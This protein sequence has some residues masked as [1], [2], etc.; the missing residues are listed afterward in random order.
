MS[1]AITIEGT[2]FPL[3]E[4]NKNGWGIPFSEAYNAISSLKGSVIRI[5]HGMYHTNVNFLRIRM[6]RRFCFIQVGIFNN[7]NQ[8]NNI[9]RPSKMCIR[10][11]I[12]ESI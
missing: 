4:I 2:E 10:N 6:L 3:G 12:R 5:A 8:S 1:L 7:A 9:K 11:I